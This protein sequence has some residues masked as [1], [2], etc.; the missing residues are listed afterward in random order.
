MKQLLAY[1]LK[2]RLVADRLWNAAPLLYVLWQS[3]PNLTL[4]QVA[5]AKRMQESD[6]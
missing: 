1:D 5:G 2:K 4:E 6:R 3:F